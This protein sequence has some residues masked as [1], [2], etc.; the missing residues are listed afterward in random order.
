[1]GAYDELLQRDKVSLD[2]IWLRDVS[3]EDSANLPPP[4]VLAQEIVEDLEAAALVTT[5]QSLAELRNAL[6]TGHGQRSRSPA[7]PRHGR[8]AFHAA[9]TV[10]DFLLTPWHERKN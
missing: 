5:I 2:L 1:M 8:L 7:Q 10:T 3:L 4:D 6:G 9:L